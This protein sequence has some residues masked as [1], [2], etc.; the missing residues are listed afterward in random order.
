MFIVGKLGCSSATLLLKVIRLIFQSVIWQP[1]LEFES[2]L[3]HNWYLNNIVRTSSIK[4]EHV[5]KSDRLNAQVFAERNRHRDI[6]DT[7]ASVAHLK[8]RVWAT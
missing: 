7:P 3:A 6:E 8:V 1:E 5:I 2:S 4:A